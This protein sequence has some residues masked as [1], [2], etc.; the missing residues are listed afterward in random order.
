[1]NWM[2]YFIVQE[3]KCRL[4]TKVVQPLLSVCFFLFVFIAVPD[5]LWSVKVCV[6]VLV[7]CGL[8][9]SD[10]RS[11]FSTESEDSL[12]SEGEKVNLKYELFYVTEKKM[13]LIIFSLLLLLLL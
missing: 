2:L 10:S 5:E 7:R 3:Q 4:L 12:T 8:A 13:S 11:P 6:C 9:P 1:M